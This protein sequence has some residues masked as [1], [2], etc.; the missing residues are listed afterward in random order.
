[1][2]T[3][4]KT[5]KRTALRLA[6]VPAPVVEFPPQ[7]WMVH[8]KVTDDGLAMIALAAA[9]GDRKD[10]VAAL[11]GLTRKQF[12]ALDADDSEIRKA[13]EAGDAENE[14][15]LFRAL[16]Y[17]AVEMNDSNSQ[18]FLLRIRGHRESGAI[19]INTGEKKYMTLIS[20]G[21]G[22][23]ALKAFM[24]SVGQTQIEDTRATPFIIERM[25]AQGRTDD[26]IAAY[27]KDQG[28]TDGP[29]LLSPPT[30]SQGG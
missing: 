25:R 10:K 19:E 12:R 7:P 27:L 15:K 5:E 30:P 29:K 9:A 28:R 4:S 2:T 23:D 24:K 18:M 20:P 13:Y 14:S 17:R 26:D 1:M 3:L 11:L 16:N 21:Y 22:D 8:G 6:H